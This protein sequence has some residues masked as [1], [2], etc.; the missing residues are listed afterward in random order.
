MLTRHYHVIIA[1]RACRYGPETYKYCFE[2]VQ[3]QFHSL[4]SIGIA[5]AMLGTVSQQH[6][7]VLGCRWCRW[8]WVWAF[9]ARLDGGVPLV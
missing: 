6:R 4:I 8:V 9:V 7:L 5:I 3:N 2:K 1:V